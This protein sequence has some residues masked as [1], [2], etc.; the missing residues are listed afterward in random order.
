MK[1]LTGKEC[2]ESLVV[3]YFKPK[4]QPYRWLDNGAGFFA[5]D[6][7]G[8]YEYVFHVVDC[9]FSNGNFPTY[10]WAGRYVNGENPENMLS[11]FSDNGTF[12]VKT[13]KYFNVISGYLYSDVKDNYVFKTHSDK[14]SKL[15]LSDYGNNEINLPLKLKLDVKFKYIKGRYLTSC[16]DVYGDAILMIEVGLNHYILLKNKPEYAEKTL[17]ECLDSNETNYAIRTNEQFEVWSFYKGKFN[18]KIPEV[19]LSEVFEAFENLETNNMSTQNEL[20]QS[21]IN[22]QSNSEH[23]II[24]ENAVVTENKT[25]FPNKLIVK[26]NFIENN[27]LVF[28]CMDSHGNLVSMIQAQAGIEK[29]VFKFILLED[30]P[31]YKNKTIK[32]C[33]DS[34]Q[35]NK[36]IVTDY[37]FNV[38]EVVDCKYSDFYLNENALNLN[39]SKVFSRR[40]ELKNQISKE[41]HKINFPKDSPIVDLGWETD[42][43]I[44]NVGSEELIENGKCYDDLIDKNSVNSSKFEDNEVLSTANVFIPEKIP[45]NV[46]F[47][48]PVEKKSDM[49]IRV[50]KNAVEYGINMKGVLVIKFVSKCVN[51]KDDI[52]LQKE[53][54]KD[55]I[56]RNKRNGYE[57]MFVPVNKVVNEMVSLIVMP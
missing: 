32:E 46:K 17:K 8:S 10:L 35:T 43:K 55:F 44:K 20:P 50:P 1:E 18:F 4:L 5:K 51:V 29:N 31:E 21:G 22:I 28:Y 36:L 38:I 34:E 24:Q 41:Y 33:L 39:F 57:T 42:T 14:L 47:S 48:S 19:K 49:G 53:I 40:E 11:Y 12:F 9:D 54:H 15:K 27:C 6:V 3:D 45:E 25:K 16:K 7:I 23:K 37:G 2:H 26:S 13:D 56:E 52:K 30:N